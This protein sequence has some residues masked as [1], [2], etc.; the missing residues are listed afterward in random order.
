MHFQPGVDE[1]SDQP[2]P[3]R[4]LMIRAISRAKV[5]TVERLVIRMVR[6]KR[7]KADWREQFA[8]GHINYRFPVR[9]VQHRVI[10]RDGEKLIWP[11]SCIHA[12]ATI[13]V[14]DIVKVS[15]FFEPETSIE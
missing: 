13:D 12:A 9:L 7:T 10:Q 14:H 15:A 8:L 11:A 2:G 3:N 4:A 6:R 5:S 1:G